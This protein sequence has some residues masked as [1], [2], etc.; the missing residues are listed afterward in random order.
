MD[1]QRIELLAQC[2]G[3]YTNIVIQEQ[4]KHLIEAM[5]CTCKTVALLKRSVISKK[6]VVNRLDVCNRCKKLKELG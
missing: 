1:K 6:A 5:P 4:T 2:I 3:D